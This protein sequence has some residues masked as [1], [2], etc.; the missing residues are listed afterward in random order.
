MAQLKYQDGIDDERKRWHTALRTMNINAGS[1]IPYDAAQVLAWR[2]E[3]AE[4][5]ALD[6]AKKVIKACQDEDI[7]DLN[8]VLDALNAAWEI[9]KAKFDGEMEGDE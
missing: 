7:T 9:Y 6:V 2:I 1:K 3:V 8:D 5:M 4:E